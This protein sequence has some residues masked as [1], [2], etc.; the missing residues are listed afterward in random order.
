MAA[1]PGLGRADRH[2]AQE[3]V[4]VGRLVLL[5]RAP[6]HGASS[7]APP[8]AVRGPGLCAPV[9]WAS[10]ALV[11]LGATPGANSCPEAP[12]TSAATA[13]TAVAA[14]PIRYHR[15]TRPVT[16]VPLDIRPLPET[17]APSADNG[18]RAS[19]LSRV[20]PRCR[21]R[22]EVGIVP[23][24][25]D[26]FRAHYRADGVDFGSIR[27]H[28]GDIAG[29][30]GD[31]AC[32]ALGA[33]AFTV[34]TDIY[35]AA[36][37]FRPG[38]RDGLWLLAHEVAHVVQQRGGLIPAPC[39]GTGSALT[40]MPAGTAEEHAA[41]RAADALIAGRPVTFGTSRPGAG[42]EVE[43]D[44]RPV[45]QRYMAWEHSMLGDL[46]P[47]QV[48][49]VADGDAGPVA[50][51]RDLL[52]ELGRAP[53]QADEERLRAAHPGLDPVRLRGS[54]LVV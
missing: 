47:A 15:L 51:Y 2:G 46:D 18:N 5:A 38:T 43:A 19:I 11:V 12:S 32:R 34:G 28:H 20:K 36:G 29:T 3:R 41:D 4:R 39:P 45:L 50:G 21:R 26:L 44:R 54:G 22:L 52:A 10:T 17:P 25:A 40:V 6:R 42:V 49:A 14:A 1:V 33:R 27:V 37:A 7:A 53:R 35:F 16:G 48:Q 31:R 8:A 23:K 9:S 13:T 24:L 30:G